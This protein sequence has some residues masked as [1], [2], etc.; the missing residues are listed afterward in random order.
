MLP[1]A[2]F[3]RVKNISLPHGKML[4]EIGGNEV[5]KYQSRRAVGEVEK[6]LCRPW[7]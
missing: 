3:G 1:E 2:G 4:P 7:S 6:A 5:E